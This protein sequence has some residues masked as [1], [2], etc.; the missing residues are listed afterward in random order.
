MNGWGGRMACFDCERLAVERDARKRLYDGWLARFGA[1]TVDGGGHMALEAAV[2]L[3]RL[4]LDEVDADIAH[5]Q[6]LHTAQIS[7]THSRRVN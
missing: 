5:H 2:S 4:A 1:S 7:R 6:Y 3:A